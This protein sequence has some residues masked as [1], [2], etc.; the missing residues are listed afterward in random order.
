MEI[1]DLNSPAFIACCCLEEPPPPL[2]Y[3]GSVTQ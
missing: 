2:W 3:Y 1:N